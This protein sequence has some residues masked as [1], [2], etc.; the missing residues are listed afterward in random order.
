MMYYERYLFDSVYMEVGNDSA[1]RS[2][3]SNIDG[4]VKHRMYYDERIKH[5]ST[6]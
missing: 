2:T 5:Q 3:V 6:M 4:R 1:F